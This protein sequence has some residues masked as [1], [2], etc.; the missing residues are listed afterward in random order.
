[1]N[2]DL[3]QRAKLFAGMAGLPILFIRNLFGDNQDYWLIINDIKWYDPSAHRYVTE[4][5][6]KVISNIINSLENLSQD[7]FLTRMDEIQQTELTFP[8][9]V[10]WVK[11]K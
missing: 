4:V 9:S 5:R 8:D 3:L 7:S 6:G 10:N 2:K 11:I 1:M